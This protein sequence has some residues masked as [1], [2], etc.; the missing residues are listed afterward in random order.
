MELKQCRKWLKDTKL[1]EKN[2]NNILL[3]IFSLTEC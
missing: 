2:N 3:Y 1:E